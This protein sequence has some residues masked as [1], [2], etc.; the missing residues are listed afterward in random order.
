MTRQRPPDDPTPQRLG[1]Y[2]LVRPISTGG[3]ARVYE[4]RLESMAG[5]APKVAICSCLAK[6]HSS[7][8]VLEQLQLAPLQTRASNPQP[9]YAAIPAQVV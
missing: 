3:M 2:R 9:T 6:A 1:R 8:A 7:H 4:A 5:V